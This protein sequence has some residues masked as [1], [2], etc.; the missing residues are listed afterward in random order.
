M[1][2]CPKRSL[3]FASASLYALYYSENWPSKSYELQVPQNP[4]LSL[5]AG[6]VSLCNQ[7][8][9]ELTKYC[10]SKTQHCGRCPVM[11]E[12]RSKHY[13][14]GANP[15]GSGRP[16]WFQ[17]DGSFFP[18]F[19]FSVWMAVGFIHRPQLLFMYQRPLLPHTPA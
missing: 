13:R 16:F 4:N 2:S 5:H 11:Q 6:N 15:P 8:S 9:W 3:S 1:T 18:T 17:H 12:Q 10:V 19:L 7:I 14:D